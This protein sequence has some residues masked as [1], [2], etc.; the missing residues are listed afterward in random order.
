M[1]DPRRQLPSASG[2]PR[3]ALCP[4]SFLAEQLVDWKEEPD[5]DAESGT[6][7]HAALACETVNLPRDL[8][9]EERETEAL[10]RRLASE[11]GNGILNGVDGVCSREQRLWCP[12]PETLAPLFSGQFDLLVRGNGAVIVL[13]FKTGRNQVQ[14]ETSWQLRALAAL[15]VENGLVDDSERLFLVIVQPWASPQTKGVEYTVADRIAALEAARAMAKAVVRPGQPRVPSEDACRYC[16]AKAT[17][18]EAQAV[19]A[20]TANLTLPDGRAGEVLDAGTV[21]WLLDRCSLAERVIGGIRARAK[22]MLMEKP[23][24]VPGWQLRPGALRQKIVDVGGL[25][26]RLAPLGVP[27]EAFTAACGMTKTDFK[28]LVRQTLGLKGGRLDDKT[29]ELLSG[30][31]EEKQT[32]PQLQRIGETANAKSE[33]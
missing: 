21:A 9:A 11:L 26:V 32:A 22:A 30:L 5:P 4:G 31:V 19:V 3:Y 1:S 17:C 23:G 18:P 14:A 10:C 15:V 27:V 25:W 16:R 8:T 28:A 6:R 7:I 29:A 20:L 33:E 13:D 12:D 24:S 2:F